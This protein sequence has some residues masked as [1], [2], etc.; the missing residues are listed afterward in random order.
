[1]TL[2][3]YKEVYSTAFH[4]SSGISWYVVDYVYASSYQYMCVHIHWF[5]DAR[6]TIVSLCWRNRRRRYPHHFHRCF[7]FI[8]VVVLVVVVLVVIIIIHRLR[9]FCWMLVG[10]SLLAK[11]HII[12]TVSIPTA[13][14]KW[15]HLPY[16]P[17]VHVIFVCCERVWKRTAENKITSKEEKEEEEERRGREKG[18]KRPAS[19]TAFIIQH[20]RILLSSVLLHFK[21]W[22]S[23]WPIYKL[24]RL[25]YKYEQL[26]AFDI[27]R[28]LHFIFVYIFLIGMIK[29]ILTANGWMLT[30]FHIFLCCLTSC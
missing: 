21:S 22:R 4:V 25:A 14:G 16:R 8:V 30:E 2:S 5:S 12:L 26:V 18:G 10:I 3:P 6:F 19:T 23:L 9:R 13:F 24:V 17:R 11:L 7:Y 20:I 27:L 29:R 28:L 1:M 15:T